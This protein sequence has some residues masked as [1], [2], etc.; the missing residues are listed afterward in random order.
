MLKNNSMMQ[1][2]KLKSGRKKGTSTNSNLQR[3]IA[4]AK[5]KE[6]KLKNK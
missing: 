6:L 5:A 4:Q 2:E 1:Y 3:L